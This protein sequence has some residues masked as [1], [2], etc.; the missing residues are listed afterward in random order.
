MDNQGLGQP[1]FGSDRA[2]LGGFGSTSD[3]GQAPAQ[4]YPNLGSPSFD[5]GGRDPNLR[6][7]AYDNW[8]TGAD[9]H[10]QP[11]LASYSDYNLGN[12]APAGS[13]NGLGSDAG[14]GSDPANGHTGY[15]GGYANGH[16][17]YADGRVGGA[18]ATREDDDYDD[19]D[20]EDYDDYEPKRS[21]MRTL[22][23]SVG[24]LTGAIIVGGGLAFVYATV[25]APN[26]KGLNPLVRSGSE[27]S[28]VAPKDPGGTKFANTDSKLL[29]RL[30][31][32]RGAPAS[33]KRVRPVSTLVVRPDGSLVPGSSSS[34]SRADSGNTASSSS[35]SDA[36][37]D[38]VGGR[39]AIPGL[40]IV[41]ANPT[42]P[43]AGTSEAPAAADPPAE[44]P[45]TPPIISTVKT[46]TVTPSVSPSAPPSVDDASS[47]SIPLPRRNRW[48]DRSRLAA[49]TP[50]VG[51][52]ATP[53]AAA[54]PPS[55]APS[56]PAAANGYVAVLASK[57]SRIQALEAFAD[58]R[59]KYEGALQGR[60]PD[61]QAADLSSRG[62]GTMYRVVVGPPGSRESANSVCARLRNVGYSQCWVKAY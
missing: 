9:P 38:N 26:G 7:S 46:R 53:P 18:L 45:R 8:S 44:S 32:A 23:I 50:A 61:I 2:D 35:A 47:S 3:Y 29:G 21:W 54:A 49:A 19:Y 58:L 60:V 33:D 4:P 15:P 56:G 34:S 1:P 55:A 59:Q 25:V 48:I 57:G 11:G 41:G 51:A 43:S 62:L 24:A 14:W 12:Y 10:G 28:K 5:L 13:D 22:V 27:P 37:S 20:D 6:G 30:D 17:A 36:G 31:R 40:T 39:I 52:S 16:A 42:L